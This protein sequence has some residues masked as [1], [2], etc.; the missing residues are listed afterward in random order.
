MEPLSEVETAAA[1][2]FKRWAHFLLA[3]NRDLF[4]KPA[5]ELPGVGPVWTRQ[6]IDRWLGLAEAPRSGWT[7]ESA[8]EEARARI[9]RKK[10]AVS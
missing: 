10:A 2:G 9:R 7:K 4:P 8:E 3:R 1:A 5:R 6:Q